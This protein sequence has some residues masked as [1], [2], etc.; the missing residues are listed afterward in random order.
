MRNSIAALCRCGDVAGDQ[1]PLHLDCTTHGVDDAGELDEEAIAR[2]LDDATA[3]LGD[4]GSA[5]SRRTVCSAASVP[6]S[7][8]PISRE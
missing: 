8:S 2:G 6:S 4:L 5:S 7:S 1:F 3:V